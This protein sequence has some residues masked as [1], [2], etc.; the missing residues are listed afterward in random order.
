MDSRCIEKPFEGLELK[1]R[2]HRQ[3]EPVEMEGQ[4]RQ[5]RSERQINEGVCDENIPNPR[6]QQGLGF[7]NFR[8]GG[9]DRSQPK[10][11]LKHPHHLVRLAVRPQ[12]DNRRIAAV[13]HGAKIGFEFPSFDQYGGSS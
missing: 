2:C 13:L 10:L 6:G 4:S 8:H 3:N 9:P 5:P 1:R 11:T 7:G 12:L